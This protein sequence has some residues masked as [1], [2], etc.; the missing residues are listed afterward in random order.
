MLILLFLLP[1]ENFYAAYYDNDLPPQWRF[2]SAPFDLP[3][4]LGGNEFNVKIL[5]N[6]AFVIPSYSNATPRWMHLTTF[7][8]SI[9]LFT[10]D[11]SYSIVADDDL[12]PGTYQYSTTKDSLY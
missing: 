5:D 11:I 8:I 1:S 9:N 7:E 6:Y 4:N 12:F 10:K 2:I 3:A